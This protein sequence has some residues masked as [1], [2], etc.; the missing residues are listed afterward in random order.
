MSEDRLPCSRGRTL[1]VSMALATLGL[2]I[3]LSASTS[4]VVERHG[5][6]RW[7]GVWG[8]WLGRVRCAL[9]ALP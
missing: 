3:F 7:I 1:K 6:L 9:S 8:W 4:C 5:V 2:V